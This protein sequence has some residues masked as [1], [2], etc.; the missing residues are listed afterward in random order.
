MAALAS[1]APFDLV[2]QVARASFELRRP[3]LHTLYDAIAQSFGI[4]LVYDR[5]LGNLPVSGDFRLQDVSLKEA[6]EAASSISHTFVAPTDPR[7][8]IVAA[9]SPQ[10]RGE[11]ERQVLGSFHLENPLTPQQLAEISNAL[12]NIVDLRRVTQ[13]SRTNWITVL[14]RSRQVQVAGQFLQTLDRPAGEVMLEVDVWEIDTNRA[15]DLGIS[16][17]QPFPLQFLGTGSAMPS[18][19]LLKWGKVRTLYGMQVPGLTAFLNSSSSLVR[20]HQV[21]HLRASDGQEARLL[22]GSRFPVVTASISPIGLAEGGNQQD[23]NEGFIPVIQFQ[24]VGVVVHATPHLHAAGEM[25]LQLDFA[26]RA[27]GATAENGIPS[28]TN[29]QM[30]NQVRLGFQEA[31]LLGGILNRTYRANNSGYP[32]LSRLPL[33]GWLFGRRER[34]ESDT[35]LLILVR[36]M[37]V[38][39]APAEEFASRAIFFGKELTGLPAPVPVPA[40]QPPQPGAQPGVPPQPG[41]TPGPGAAP[42]PGVAPVP[43]QTPQPGAAPVPSQPP[44]Q[45][46]PGG[47]FPQGVGLPPGLVPGRPQQPTPQPQP[48]SPPSGQ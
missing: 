23:A 19:P 17:P 24:D 34:Q 38:R 40:E 15:R 27:V 1:S 45:G 42:Q 16:P 25:T 11:Y 4:R 20:T 35:E 33:V 13:D 28:F 46:I 39:S 44:F 10:K 12:R 36:P 3:D 7:T 2:P 43:G 8:G 32:W 5:D 29:R 47:V 9:D 21:L 41:V 31:Y 14:G 30:T 48:E 6:L 22:V 26:L 37:I 18:V